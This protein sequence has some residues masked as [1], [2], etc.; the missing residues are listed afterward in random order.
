MCNTQD[1]VLKH[2]NSLLS[3]L[4]SGKIQCITFELLKEKIPDTEQ[5]NAIIEELDNN[6]IYVSPELN[7]NKLT[8]LEEAKLCR[9]YKLGTEAEK[10]LKENENLTP[11]MQTELKSMVAEK[12]KA[13]TLLEN[14]YH[15]FIRKAAKRFNPKKHDEEDFIYYALLG[16]IK[17]LNEVDFEN[18]ENSL[19]TFAWTKM[20]AEVQNA[21][22]RYY[23][24]IPVSHLI[25]RQKQAYLNYKA[26]H[27][28]QID[29]NDLAK[30]LNINI[31]SE[32]DLIALSHK[33]ILFE[34][35][36]SPAVSLQTKIN[37]HEDKDSE[38]SDLIPSQE[39]GRMESRIK[40]DTKMKRQQIFFS[41][42]T[43]EEQLIWGLKTYNEMKRDEILEYLN[44]N[45][46][47]LKFEKNEPYTREFVVK[48]YKKAQQ[49]ILNKSEEI[50]I[51]LKKIEV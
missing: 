33:I 22:E 44:E 10:I 35:V 25:L 26:E 39:T 31:K 19:A 5:R 24:S 20:L 51:K 9:K 36:T 17:A 46:L 15:Y 8:P 7:S 34:N 14:K 30:H 50:K 13:F 23:A 6:G 21:K 37:N 11:E 4:I 27:N 38:L 3:D 47:Y 28:G 45:K 49:K 43:L 48:T 1:I 40:E 42:L 41:Y 12:E 2:V 18:H 16:F 29:L 32:K